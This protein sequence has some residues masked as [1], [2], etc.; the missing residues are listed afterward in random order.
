MFAHKGE[1]LE[2]YWDMTLRTLDWGD[3]QGPN[4]IVDDGG[5]MTMMVLD[6]AE[7]EKRYEANK[8]LPDPERVE[9]DDE[10]ALFLCLRKTIPK[11]PTRFR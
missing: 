5:D 3:G 8:E 7:W 1:T 11:F 9:T 4:M 2:E 10:K 6:G